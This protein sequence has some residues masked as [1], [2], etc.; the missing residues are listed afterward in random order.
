[1]KPYCPGCEAKA[2]QIADL[3]R[4]LAEMRNWNRTRLL[5]DTLKVRPTIARML[6][7]LYDGDVITRE[8]LAS[9]AR[10][11]LHYAPPSTRASS[12]SF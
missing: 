4:E 3:K 9:H 2:E 10:V 7:R 11:L 1:M 6:V 12:P 5:V 8:A